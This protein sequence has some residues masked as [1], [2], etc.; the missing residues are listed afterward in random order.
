MTRVMVFGSLN[1]DLIAEVVSL[2]QAGETVTGRTL[3]RLGGGKG[4]NQAYAAARLSRR[5]TAVHIVACVGADEAGEQLVEGMRAEGIGVSHVVAVDDSSGLAMIAVAGDGEN[6]IVVIPGANHGWPLNFV[7]SVP[8]AQDDVV[9]CQLE[10]SMDVVAEIA[11]HAKEAGAQLIVNAAPYD[12]RVIDILDLVDVL[13]VNKQEGEALFGVT[14]IDV[15]SVT[16]MKCFAGQLIVTLGE[17][18]ALVSTR[19]GPAIQIDALPVDAIDTVG[20]GDAFVGA[21][22]IALAEGE[23]V[24]NAAQIA[25]AAGGVTA[26]I[27]GARHSA[28]SW[29]LV[30][31]L[32]KA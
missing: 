14:P 21:L 25:N 20:A 10:I 13:V 1:L 27:P 8:L 3:R 32:R 23:T 9:V 28:L 29:A 19:E 4:G 11:R 31:S 17:H 24:K 16:G 15:D 22:A 30:D 6:T 2:P 5:G 18:G 7:Q 26:T 12:G